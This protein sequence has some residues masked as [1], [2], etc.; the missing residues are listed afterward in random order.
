MT[1]RD[2]EPTN[3]LQPYYPSETPDI[4]GDGRTWFAILLSIMLLLSAAYGVLSL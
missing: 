3:P 1:E 2:P 4:P